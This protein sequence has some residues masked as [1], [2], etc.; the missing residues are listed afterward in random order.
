M[1]ALRSPWKLAFKKSPLLSAVG[2]LK[3]KDEIKKTA[4]YSAL[5]KNVFVSPTTER[6][7]V[8]HVLPRKNIHKVYEFPF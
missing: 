8:T 7:I 6:K 3:Q 5:L 4:V 1:S 2:K